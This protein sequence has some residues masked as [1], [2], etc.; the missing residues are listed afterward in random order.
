MGLPESF[1]GVGLWQAGWGRALQNR[2]SEAVLPSARSR[3]LTSEHCWHTTTS[4]IC[5]P[6]W[7]HFGGVEEE[8][9]ILFF[10]G[11]MKGLQSFTV[12]ECTSKES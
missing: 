6:T 2:A 7:A 8:G 10:R 12:K 3:A 4:Y 9:S 11:Q 1:F 5:V